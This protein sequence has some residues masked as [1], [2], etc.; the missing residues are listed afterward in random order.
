MSVS[1]ESSYFKYQVEEKSFSTKH[2]Y[3]QKHCGTL[4]CQETNLKV[5]WA[6]SPC[7]LLQHLCTKAAN[8][9]RQM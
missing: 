9:R 7:R 8:H 6:N 5:H 1:S 2:F 4:C 3:H